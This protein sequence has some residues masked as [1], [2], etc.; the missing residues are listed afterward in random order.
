MPNFCANNYLIF[1]HSKIS[2]MESRT[3]AEKIFDTL[4]KKKLKGRIGN[5]E[6]SGFLHLILVLHTQH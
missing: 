2:E 6:S 3:F 4:I 5:K 1:K